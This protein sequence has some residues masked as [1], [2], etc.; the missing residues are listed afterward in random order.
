MRQKIQKG[1]YLIDLGI[2]VPDVLVL[3]QDRVPPNKLEKACEAAAPRLGKVVLVVEQ[4]GQCVHGD[5]QRQR[6]ACGNPR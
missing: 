4:A 6:L 5:A 2:K 1:R 3:G